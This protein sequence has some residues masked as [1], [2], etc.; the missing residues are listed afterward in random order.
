[1]LF[2]IRFFLVLILVT[3][4]ASASRGQDQVPAEPPKTEPAPPEETLPAP[5]EVKVTPDVLDSE[6]SLR[7]THI[8]EATAWFT[9]P[10][11]RVDEGVAFLSGTT[12]DEKYR[13]W[14]GELA[15]NTQ[16]VVA[17]V[18]RIQVR[19]PP[20]WDMSSPFAPVQEMLRNAVRAIPTIIVAVTIL[21]LTALGMFVSGWLAE[22]TI[23]SRVANRLLKGVMRKALMLIVL[24]F[25]IYL[26][27]QISGLTRLAATVIGG[28][29]LLGLVIGIAFRDIAE[30]FLAS[31]LISMQN[32]FR[33]GD[34]IEI[35][36]VQGYVQRVNTRGTLLMTLEGNHVQIPNSTIYKSKILNFTSNPK[37]RLDFL[38]GVGYDVP[39]TEAQRIA[40]ETLEQHPAVL[41]DPEPI[42]LVED[43]A[44]ATVNLRLY[45]WIDGHKFSV[46]KVNS[47]LMRQVKTVFEEQGFSMPGDAREIIFPQGVPIQMTEGAQLPVPEAAPPREIAR[48]RESLIQDEE[49]VS[50]AEG[51]L[52]N[53]YSDIKR[54]SEAARDPEQDSTDLLTDTPET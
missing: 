16:D 19:E 51:E 14:A 53:E 43:L 6:I 47:A 9:D 24:L 15:R 4:G 12:G 25:G 35:E 21:L 26:V 30:N 20:L 52:T 1:M 32:P 22:R 38:I 37:V 2:L 17:V 11:V 34:L 10:E 41:N 27:L 33:Y 31:I 44:A 42:V 3:T 18:N 36:G 48:P 39:L 8:L 23:L 13:T 5:K 50:E 7:L 45:Y 49:S 54:Q 29:G 28:T 46:L 40:K